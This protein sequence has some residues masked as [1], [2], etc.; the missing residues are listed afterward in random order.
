VG[1]NTFA[2]RSGVWAGLAVS[3]HDPTRPATARFERVEVR[4]P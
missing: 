1:Q 3:S 4:V 2:M